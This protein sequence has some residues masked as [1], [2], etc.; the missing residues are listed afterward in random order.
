M[1]AASPRA[2]GRDHALDGVRGIAAMMVFFSHVGMMTWY[3]K[4]GGPAPSA[5]EYIL[6]HLGAPAVDLFFVLSGYVLAASL[7]RVQLDAPTMFAFMKR[8]WVRLM[9][10]AWTGVV[11]G[12]L[13]KFLIVP[14]Q[15]EHLVGMARMNLPLRWQDVLGALTFL[16]PMPDTARINVPLWTLVLE[17]YASILIVFTVYGLRSRGPWFLIPAFLS[18]VIFATISNR[19]E[20]MTLP[21]FVLGVAVRTYAPPLPARSINVA[22]AMGILLLLSR[23]FFGEFGPWHRYAS[24]LGA[25]FIIIAV[26]EGAA[27]SFLESRPIAWLGAASYPFYAFHFPLLLACTILFSAAGMQTNLAGLTSLPIALLLAEIGRRTIEAA[28]V[29][30]SRKV[31]ADLLKPARA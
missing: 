20:F 6:W 2:A 14:L 17:M 16:L 4:D 24:G 9:P 13:V 18:W 7:E 5:V 12:L 21:L 30:A 3:P 11:L 23:Y 8:R 27:R 15:T 1:I 31:G 26:R 22:L 28:S 29:R 25:A 19:I 10:I